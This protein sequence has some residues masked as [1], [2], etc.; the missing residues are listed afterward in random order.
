MYETSLASLPRRSCS[1]LWQFFTLSIQQT[2]FGRSVFYP[3]P[4]AESPSDISGPLVDDVWNRTRGR[5]IY[6]YKQ[7]VGGL[8]VDELT[9]K[10]VVRL[11]LVGSSA[12]CTTHSKHITHIIKRTQTTARARIRGQRCRAEVCVCCFVLLN[13]WWGNLGPGATQMRLGL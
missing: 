2:T 5:E 12:T 4:Q 8:T 3:E 7:R 13:H 9:M 10:V 6:I 11:V 1:G